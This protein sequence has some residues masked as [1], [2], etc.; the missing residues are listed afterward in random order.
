MYSITEIYFDN[1]S[2]HR[3]LEVEIWNN[4]VSNISV[5]VLI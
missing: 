5:A 3:L 1:N 4:Y 2:I